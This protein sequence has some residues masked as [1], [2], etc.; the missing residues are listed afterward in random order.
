MANQQ[1]DR[2]DQARKAN[3]HTDPEVFDHKAQNAAAGDSPTGA[4][5]V[6]IPSTVDEHVPSNSEPEATD[7][8]SANTP[9]PD[10]A[11]PDNPNSSKKK[12]KG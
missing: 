11:G 6:E 4:G 8:P 3:I 10:A 2:K 7:I 9:D 1:A 12:Q 5:G